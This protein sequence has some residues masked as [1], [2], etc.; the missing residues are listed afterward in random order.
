MAYGPR[1]LA[2]LCKPSVKR[3]I[4]AI[5]VHRFTMD[6]V[7]AWALK[8]RADGTFY[9]PHFASDA[10]W[11][12]NTVVRTR[13]DGELDQRFSACETS[14]ETWPLGKALAAPYRRA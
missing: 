7:P 12:S 14:G 2:S 4:L 3:D 8:E 11:L 1:T 9:A 6:H 13:K 10:E 5:F